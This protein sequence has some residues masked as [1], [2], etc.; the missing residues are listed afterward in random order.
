MNPPAEA[1]TQVRHVPTSS[2][3]AL[4]STATRS[5]GL[6]SVEAGAPGDADDPAVDAGGAVAAG[7]TDGGRGLDSASLCWEP[8]VPSAANHRDPSQ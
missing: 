7:A 1:F 5:P 4:P 8:C 3:A 2:P 6:Q